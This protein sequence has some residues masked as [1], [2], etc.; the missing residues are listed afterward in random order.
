MPSPTRTEETKWFWLY[1]ALS[2]EEERQASHRCA[3]S[4]IKLV[5]Q[6]A[7]NQGAIQCFERIIEHQQ[8]KARQHYKSKL[9]C[10]NKVCQILEDVVNGGEAK[11][12]PEAQQS[13]SSAEMASTC[14]D[15][16]FEHS[17]PVPRE[18]SQPARTQQTSKCTANQHEHSMI[19]QL[20]APR[21]ERMQVEKKAK[22]KQAKKKARQRNA[23]AKCAD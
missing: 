22:N 1:G 21:W 19:V 23:I 14:R 16:Q 12:E 18:Q 7:H 8:N 4:H 2:A 20:Q 11:A 17:K 5:E 15:G 6:F 13:A 9:E 3:Q 10:I